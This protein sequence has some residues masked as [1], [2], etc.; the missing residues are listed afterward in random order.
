[1]IRT[2]ELSFI[3]KLITRVFLVGSWVCNSLVI[4]N[5]VTFI[6]SIKSIST[7][8]IKVLLQIVSLRRNNS[9]ISSWKVYIKWCSSS[10]LS[11]SW[12]RSDF[13]VLLRNCIVTNDWINRGL[14]NILVSILIKTKNFIISSEK[15]QKFIFLPNCVSS[16][17]EL[18][19]LFFKVFLSVRKVIVFW[20]L[21]P[22]RIFLSLDRHYKFKQIIK[23]KKLT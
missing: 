10:S 16:E 2:S 8:L 13:W 22:R 6:P 19:T 18:L 17:F 1:M 20:D 12:M 14:N 23:C 21:C 7:K 15:V 3:I 4:E 5:E 11:E 9:S